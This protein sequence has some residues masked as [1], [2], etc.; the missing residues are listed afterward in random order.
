[1]SWSTDWGALV[2]AT[3]AELAAGTTTVGLYGSSHPRAVQALGQLA[4]QI[5]TLL[6]G[7]E[8]LAFVLLG[9]E[10]FV[11]GQP[12][13]RVSR[14]APAVIRRLRRR[15][16][17]H[18][19]FRRGVNQEEL[20]S[21]L[22]ELA[23]ADDSPVRSRPNIQVGRVE[24]SE[25]EL[26]GPDER[27]GGRKGR[28][29]ATVRDR[30]SV[31]QE[32]FADVV[33]GRPLAVGQLEV[34]ARTLL[35]ALG[36]DPHFLHH[37]APWEGEERWQAVHAHNVAAVTMGLARL[38]N[39]GA[40]PCRDLGVAALVHDI[41]KVFFPAEL[42]SRELELGGEEIE[43]V[44]D[45]PKGGLETLLRSRQ[46]PLVALIVVCEHHLYFNGTGYPRLGRPR[47]PH[48]AARLVTVA[49]TFDL[50]FTGRGRR[51]LLTRE[52]TTA[53]LADRQGSMLDPGWASALREV[54]EAGPRAQ[55]P[56]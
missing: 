18:V 4:S 50:L 29:L 49:D 56:G 2:Q 31:I 15:G 5:G 9:E 38:A 39:V 13:T 33:A 43:L 35:E 10:L 1:M 55:P 16:V 40:V 3:I 8:E 37:L 23:A 32:C 51:G 19:S 24:L 30:V 6:A 28:R 7:E 48:P 54:L 26:G 42:L 53:W 52:G 21:F 46:L 34:V 17:E 25:S 14:Q 44:L 45:H 41:G 22:E 12:F 20:R 11:Q 36:G 47:R 27:Q